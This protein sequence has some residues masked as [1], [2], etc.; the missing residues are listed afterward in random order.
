MTISVVDS[1][2]SV[3]ISMNPF[4]GP[5]APPRDPAPCGNN[6]VHAP[7]EYGEDA[8][9]CGGLRPVGYEEEKEDSR[10][11]KHHARRYEKH[12]VR[13]FLRNYL[14]KA[15]LDKERE[16]DNPVFTNRIKVIEYLMAYA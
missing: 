3:I 7:H 15:V 8:S 11:L 2:T 5:P 14:A 9:W 16:P 12:I 6:S 1:T 10:R 4:A 13:L